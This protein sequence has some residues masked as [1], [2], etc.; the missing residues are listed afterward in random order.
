M[1]SL[2]VTYLAAIQVLKNIPANG[3]ILVNDVA[4]DLQLLALG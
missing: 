1:D 4:D 3:S 2:L